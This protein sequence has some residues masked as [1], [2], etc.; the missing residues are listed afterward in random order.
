M[1][2]EKKIYGVEALKFIRG[3]IK[4]NLSKKHD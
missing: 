4:N 3:V 2:D 1:R